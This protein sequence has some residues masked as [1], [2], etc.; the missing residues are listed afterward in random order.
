MDRTMIFIDGNNF[1]HA[2]RHFLKQKPKVDFKKLVQRICEKSANKHLLRTYF[3]TVNEPNQQGIVTALKHIPRF[4]VNN[5]GYLKKIPIPEIE[6][7]PNDPNTYVTEEKGTDVNLVTDLLIGA[8][9]NSYDTAI[10]VSAEGDYVG[11]VSEIKKIGKI[12][13][14]VITE[15]QPIS[16]ELKQIADVVI[17]LNEHDFEI[18]WLEKYVSQ[19]TSHGS[20]C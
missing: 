16:N 20:L 8:Y 10:I 1:Y 12:V 17:E 4:T 14:I 3:Y 2:V 6:F 13:E 5:K 9:M 11:P 19:R 7:N 15:N 18:C